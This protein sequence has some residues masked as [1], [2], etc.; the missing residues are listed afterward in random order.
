MIFLWPVVKIC[1]VK[2]KKKKENEMNRHVENCLGFFSQDLRLGFKYGDLE[3][4]VLTLHIWRLVDTLSWYLS[5]LY[6][7]HIQ[8]L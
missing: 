8:P 7:L 3:K 1:I 2:K 6:E 4:V 5:M